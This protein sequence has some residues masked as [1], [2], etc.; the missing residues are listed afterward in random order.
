[1]ANPTSIDGRPAV[2]AVPSGPAEQVTLNP[3]RQYSIA[4]TGKDTGGATAGQDVYL[5]TEASVDAD[6]SEGPD[7]YILADGEFIVLPPGIGVLKF[8]SAGTPTIKVMPGA[9]LN[10]QW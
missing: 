8:Q 7:K 4:H 6:G 2:L 10:G 1:M 5:A 3:D 9:R